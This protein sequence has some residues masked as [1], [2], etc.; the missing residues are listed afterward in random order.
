MEETKVYFWNG[1][2]HHEM[3]AKGLVTATSATRD[4]VMLQGYGIEQDI[5]DNL[6]AKSN[7][8]EELKTFDTERA[9]NFLVTKEKSESR[10]VLTTDLQSAKRKFALV[11]PKGSDNYS[12]FMVGNLLN[13]GNKKFQNIA[14]KIV[15]GL[16]KFLPA[17][18]KVGITE[19]TVNSLNTQLAD[20]RALVNGKT[21][22]K[23]DSRNATEVR[24][25]AMSEVY[26]LIV[27]ICEA[28][29]AAWADAGS[30]SRYQDY[31]I[32]R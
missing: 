13:A 20:Y 7:F 31:I 6:V 23:N 28:G 12:K 19:E 9:L 30:N 26:N 10:L 3:A 24:N 27:T 22:N 14:E 18:A 11:Y 17:L 21:I 4:L 16:V 25:E 8:L 5:I 2:S 15:E 32:S 1:L 29:K